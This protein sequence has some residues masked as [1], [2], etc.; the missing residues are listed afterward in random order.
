MVEYPKRYL[1]IL[2]RIEVIHMEPILEPIST[3][4]LLFAESI[5][6]LPKVLPL[7]ELRVAMLKGFNH[8]EIE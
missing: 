7:E 2:K 3:A 4:L 5:E 1:S 6:K 8:T